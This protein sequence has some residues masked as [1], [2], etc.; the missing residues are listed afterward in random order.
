MDQ[1]VSFFL[2]AAIVSL[3]LLP[4]STP[5]FRV[6]CEI[7]AGVYVLLALATALDRWSRRR[8]LEDHQRTVNQRTDEERS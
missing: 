2:G 6:V 3:L 5:E 4:L 1:R 7:T 8:E